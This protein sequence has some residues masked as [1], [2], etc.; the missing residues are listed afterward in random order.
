M[1]MM[2]APWLEGKAERFV[3]FIWKEGNV[4]EDVKC[5]IVCKNPSQ[6]RME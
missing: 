2:R 1:K 6:G 3:L 4:S 5:L